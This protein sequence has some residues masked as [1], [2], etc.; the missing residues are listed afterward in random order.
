M[1]VPGGWAVAPGGTPDWAYGG[2]IVY[3]GPE[4]TQ[5]SLRIVALLFKLTGNVDAHKILALTPGELNNLNGFKP[6]NRGASTKLAGHDAYQA[7]GYWTDNGQT[8]AAAV[9]TVAIPG[10]DGLYVLQVK[11]DGLADQLRILAPATKVIDDQTT[12]T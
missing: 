12:I 4:A 10:S 11:A 2:A 5:D 6:I 9:K 7:A 8:H 3:T 1:P